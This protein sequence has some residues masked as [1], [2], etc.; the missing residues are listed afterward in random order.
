ME[1]KGRATS[2]MRQL[3]LK[4]DALVSQNHSLNFDKVAADLA[5]V[6]KENEAIAEKLRG[7]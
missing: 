2:E 1:A 6:R 5:K 3:E 4:S 7:K